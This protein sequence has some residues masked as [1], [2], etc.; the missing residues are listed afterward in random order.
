MDLNLA[1]AFQVYQQGRYAEARDWCAKAIKQARAGAKTGQGQ[2]SP[3]LW[4]IDGM[5]A[6]ALGDAGAAV[7]SLQRAVALAPHDGTILN[8]CGLAL[9]S[10]GQP[11]EAVVMLKQAVARLPNVAHPLCN[12]GNALRQCGQSAAAIEPLRQAT[13]L[14]PEHM[15]AWHNLGLA[16]LEQGQW[17]EA[18]QA[19]G[20]AVELSDGDN[21]ILVRQH[22][23]EALRQLGE[24]ERAFEQAR[25]AYHLSP[26]NPQVINELGLVL[27]GLSRPDQA[28]AAFAEACRLQPENVQYLANRATALFDCGQ[29]DDAADVCRQALELDP[30]NLTALSCH[31]ELL[32]I[33]GNYQQGLPYWEIR[34]AAL[35]SAG[36]FRQALAPTWD[37]SS[38]PG[39]TLLIRNEQGFG[40][41]LMMARLLT[42]AVR[43]LGP[44]SRL[45]LEC[46]EPLMSLM[47]NVAGVHTTLRR[48]RD[49]PAHDLQINLMSLPRVLGLIPETVPHAPYLPVPSSQQAWSIPA[50]DG[51]LI[52]ICWAGA[53]VPRDRSV[54]L[55]ELWT[56]LQQGAAGRS[57]RWVC[58]QAD[59]RRDN[60][61]NLS[62]LHMPPA[63][64]TF[65]DTAAIIGQLDAVVSIDTAVLHLAGALG[66][67]LAALLVKG[68][69]WRYGRPGTRSPWYPD[70]SLFRQ[71]ALYDWSQPLS[72]LSQW[73]GQQ[74]DGWFI[75]R[76]R[77]WW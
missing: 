48:G 74:L 13:R 29:Y 2:P 56:A 51:P 40:D 36:R 43:R 25:F 27:K 72:A 12:L 4:S 11:E 9:L 7:A 8:D 35:E 73:V 34:W 22:W 52:G 39:A 33:N 21:Q 57:V 59:D 20:Q 50:G 47:E 71:A 67:P 64:R 53:A 49:W 1:R 41:T 45:V 75:E 6:L 61:A 31:G 55:S 15:A 42:P 38:S 62:G 69:D 37:G 3:L 16:L 18:E 46:P 70:A 58:L 19:L 5:A 77:R 54:P 76:R 14:A 44:K 23:V 68:C 65:V 24:W 32:L 28:E 66:I 26:D 10:S 60:A 63:P 17:G 30:C